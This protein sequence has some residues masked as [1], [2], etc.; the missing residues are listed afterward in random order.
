LN[1][2]WWIPGEFNATEY[3]NAPKVYP[4]TETPK[5]RDVPYQPQSPRLAAVLRLPDE[6]GSGLLG[7]SRREFTLFDGPAASAKGVRPELLEPFE[8]RAVLRFQAQDAETIT[9][10][11]PF[12]TSDAGQGKLFIVKVFED[13]ATLLSEEEVHQ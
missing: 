8:N 2:V 7:S 5:L 6:A 4:T 10:A 9:V 1:L 3:A 11:D 13:G 12:P